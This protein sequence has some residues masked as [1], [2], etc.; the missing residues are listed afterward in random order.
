MDPLVFPPASEVEK[1]SVA[2]VLPDGQPLMDVKIYDRQRIEEILSQLQAN[3]TGYSSVMKTKAPQEYW[4]AV[5]T[6]DLMATMV[7]IGPDWLGGVD[8]R[9]EA[10][11]RSLASHYRKLDG[12]QHAKLIALLHQAESDLKVP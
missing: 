2:R 7:W 8:S 11:N 6:K 12:E 4:V 5:N 10:K 9:H 1:L 3:N